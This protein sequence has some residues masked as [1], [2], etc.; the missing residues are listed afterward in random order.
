MDD[1]QERQC[2]QALQAEATQN[3]TMVIV[4]HKSSVLPL[5]TRLIVMSG[6][7]VVM[8]GP[9][10]AVL[11]KLSSPTPATA[12]GAIPEAERPEVQTA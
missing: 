9:R 1:S 7:K 5:V 12:T 6:S 11:Q 10:D 8:D 2:L 3:K 4:T